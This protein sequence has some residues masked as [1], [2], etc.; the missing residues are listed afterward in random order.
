MVAFE[1]DR[2][3]Q[4][5]SLGHSH[6]ALMLRSN[7]SWVD[8]STTRIEICAWH[9]EALMIKPRMQGLRIA[10]AAGDEHEAACRRFG[11]EADA[12]SLFLL[13][14]QGFTGFLV[15]GIPQWREAVRELGDP[16]LFAFRV[17][18]IEQDE[19]RTE[20][21]ASVVTVANID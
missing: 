4:V 21:T 9:V 3:F 5:W 10:R 6:D 18:D 20:E 11:I 12:G 8:N 7:P 2:Y 16:S 15:S 1:S 14:T 17:P 19:G 13:E